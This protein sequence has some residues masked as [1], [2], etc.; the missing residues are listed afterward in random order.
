MLTCA[1]VSR[2]AG[3][4]RDRARRGRRH[5]SCGRAGS[6]SARVG[7]PVDLVAVGVTAALGS[8]FDRR[9]L[10][11]TGRFWRSLLRG[12]GLT[13]FDRAAVRRVET[14]LELEVA[15]VGA[16]VSSSAISSWFSRS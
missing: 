14:D 10:A 9:S 16:R 7:H 15:G 3:R 8:P 4:S 12:G 5:S 11:G 6:G 1:A 13:R 2:S